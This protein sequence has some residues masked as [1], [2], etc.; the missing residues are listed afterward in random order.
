L[1][2]GHQALRLPGRRVRGRALHLLQLRERVRRR[3]LELREERGRHAQ[4]A[5]R[6]RARRLLLLVRLLLLLLLLLLVR[7][8]LRGQLGELRDGGRGEAVLRAGRHR[9]GVVVVHARRGA[10]RAV[11]RGRRLLLLLLGRRLLRGRGAAR[12]DGA[13]ARRRAR[14][15]RARTARLVRGG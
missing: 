2:G 8:H 1:R 5:R 10:G 12:L 3:R 4:R 6:G 15:L 7:L 11:V 13:R 9:E 14:L